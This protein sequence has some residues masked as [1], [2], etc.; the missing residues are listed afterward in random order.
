[1]SRTRWSAIASLEAP[2]HRNLSDILLPCV[3]RHY[4]VGDLLQ[5]INPREV[6]L[7]NPA[8]ARLTAVRV[9][10]RGFH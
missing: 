9:V 3:L 10:K 1:M 8:D 6:I 2:L 7:V 4:A 5:V